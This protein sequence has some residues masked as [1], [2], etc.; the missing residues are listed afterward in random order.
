MV[1]GFIQILDID[2]STRM[3]YVQAYSGPFDMSA[4]I[5]SE[6]TE[7][8]L[9]GQG[10]YKKTDEITTQVFQYVSMLGVEPELYH[11]MFLNEVSK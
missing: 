6:K 3:M 7:R 4:V 8:W 9:E 2:M 5:Y 1:D 11:R 10:P